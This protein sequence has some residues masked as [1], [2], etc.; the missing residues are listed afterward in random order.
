MKNAYLEDITSEELKEKFIEQ[1]IAAYLMC[2][3]R[4]HWQVDLMRGNLKRM[5]IKVK[6][7]RTIS[8][9]NKIKDALIAVRVFNQ[10]F[11]DD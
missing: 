6:D 1:A 3:H 10:L 7:N 4:N 2:M 9:S 8:S 11:S 5:G